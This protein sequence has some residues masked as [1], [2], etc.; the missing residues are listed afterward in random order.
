M[1]SKAA[2]RSR[3]QTDFLRTYGINDR[4]DHEYEDEQFQWNDVYSRQTGEGLED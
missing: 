1:V 3:R 2:E 4:V